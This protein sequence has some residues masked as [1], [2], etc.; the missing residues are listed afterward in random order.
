MATILLCT[1]NGEA[2]DELSATI[3]AMGHTLLL[4]AES[5]E[6]LKFLEE[7]PPDLTVLDETFGPMPYRQLVS[8]I[9]SATEDEC[10]IVL[11]S[12][13]PSEVPAGVTA[14]IRRLTDSSSVIETLVRV[15]GELAVGDEP[16]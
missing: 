9:R 10:P 11:V 2:L 6:A 12:A 16:V 15:M 5:F 14:T 7:S 4:A 3:E 13:R 8:M 1:S